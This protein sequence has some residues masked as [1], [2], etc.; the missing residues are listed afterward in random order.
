MLSCIHNITTL[1]WRYI[2]LI[3]MTIMGNQYDFQVYAGKT[4]N[5]YQWG[6]LQGGKAVL[7]M[8][9][10]LP[11]CKEYCEKMTLFSIHYHSIKTVESNL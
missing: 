3:D 1:H 7:T 5:I 6:L 4:K 9:L 2:F 8:A 11:L 10:V